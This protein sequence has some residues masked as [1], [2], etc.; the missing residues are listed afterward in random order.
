LQDIKDN[1][2]NLTIIGTG[3]V[4]LITGACLE[5]P[6]NHVFLKCG[7]A[8]L[9]YVVAVDHPTSP[10]WRAKRGNPCQTVHHEKCA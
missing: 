3:Y 8:D 9:E 6:G 4:G 7:S 10:S 1:L 5:D 2:M